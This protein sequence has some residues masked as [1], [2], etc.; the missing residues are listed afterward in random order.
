MIYFRCALSH[1]RVQYN[2]SSSNTDDSPTTTISNSFLSFL[3]KSHSGRFR[4]TKGNFL[5]LIFLTAYCVY[6]LESPR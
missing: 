3:E 5:F 4:I 6:L 2:F 1:L